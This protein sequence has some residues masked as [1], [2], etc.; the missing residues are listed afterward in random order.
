MQ[1]CLWTTG[2]VWC[3]TRHSTGFVV[4]VIVVVVLSSIIFPAWMP[5]FNFVR[6]AVMP[7]GVSVS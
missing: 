6:E 3:V 5:C 7:D 4:V 2:T 1:I